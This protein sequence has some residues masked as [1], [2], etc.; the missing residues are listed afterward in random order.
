MEH[1][2]AKAK[3]RTKKVILII[4][5]LF[6]LLA[7]FLSYSIYGRNSDKAYQAMIRIFCVSR[8][9]SNDIASSFISVIHPPKHF[10]SNE[11]ILGN[12][13]GKNIETALSNLVNNGFH[14]FEQRLPAELCSKIQNYALRE[15]VTRQ[16][17]DGEIRDGEIR[18]IFDRKNPQALRYH[19]SMNQV[20]ANP[21]IQ[22]LSIDFSILT[23]AQAYLRTEP[24]LDIP[25]LFWSTG[26][27]DRGDIEAAQFFHFDMDRIK[28]LK[29]FF[30]ITDVNEETGPHCF[31]KSSHRSGGIPQELLQYGYARHSDEEVAKYYHPDQFVEFIAP[32]GT[33]IAEDTRGLHKGKP[34]KSGDRLMMQLQFSN[35]LFGSSIP[36]ASFGEIHDPKIQGIIQKFP[37]I[38]SQYSK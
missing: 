9:K 11:G 20:L 16:R 25:T 4:K 30:Y 35:S 2:I 26:L 36:K 12:M 1:L 10:P 23:V 15:K 22:K 7:G 27:H 5:D 8:G 31:V 28:W 13:T 19:L 14:V 37:R 3:F 24:I 34:I 38:Y 33:I 17:I 18:E 29:F 32:K 21:E 6:I